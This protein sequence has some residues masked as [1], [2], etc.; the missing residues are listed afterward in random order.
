M[1]I[2]TKAHTWFLYVYQKCNPPPAEP[3]L[4]PSQLVSRAW[5]EAKVRQ[6]EGHSVAVLAGSDS[7]REDSRERV[8][9]A[10]GTAADVLVSGDAENMPRLASVKSLGR[11]HWTLKGKRTML[12][13]TNSF[14]LRMQIASP[15]GGPRANKKTLLVPAHSVKKFTRKIKETRRF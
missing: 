10:G 11:R 14:S 13:C 4:L 9:G 3:A 1:K 7:E 2:Y 15:H 6:E 8:P 5:S 12:Q